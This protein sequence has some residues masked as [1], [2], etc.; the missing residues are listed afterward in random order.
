MAH[1]VEPILPFDIA[2]AMFLIPDLT[3]PLTTSELLSIHT[4]QL[5]ARDQDLDT[6]R[7]NIV[8]S[9]LMSARDFECRYAHTIKDP[10][11][12]PGDLVLVRNSAVESNHSH[13]TKPHY[14]GPMVVLTQSCNNSYH[15]T[16]LDGAVSKLRYAAF[17]LVPYHSR[18]S[19]FIPIEDLLSPE[20][21]LLLK[22]SHVDVEEVAEEDA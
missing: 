10:S 19:P 18:T 11:F 9:C 7:D 1:S 8:K 20:D 13:K 6:I 22:T 4:R 5:Q 12:N 16:E 2:L 17:R 14:F 21:L 15:L 3:H